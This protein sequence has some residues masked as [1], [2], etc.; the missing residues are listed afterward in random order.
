MPYASQIGAV[1]AAPFR[2]PST[3]PTLGHRWTE[4]V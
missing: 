3:M 1:N 2:T 4:R